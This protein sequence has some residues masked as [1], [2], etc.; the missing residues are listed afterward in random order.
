MI[1][2]RLF[3]LRD[4]GWIPNSFFVFGPQEETVPNESE[5]LIPFM[6][7]PSRSPLAKGTCDGHFT[8]VISV[9]DH[10]IFS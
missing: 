6:K 8:E 2:S 1:Q 9:C 5:Q 3:L 7:G 10:V 4:N